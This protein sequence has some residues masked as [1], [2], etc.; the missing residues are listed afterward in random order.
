MAYEKLFTPGK[1]GNV[2]IKN[3]VVMPPMMLGFGQFDGKP[4]EKMMN[5]YEER[6]IGGAGLIVTE[7]T[8]VNDFS[9]ASAFAQLAISHDY[10]I[11][12]LKEMIDRVHR[13]GAKMFIQLHHPGRQNLGLMMG[14]V[15]VSIAM[16]KLIGN[17]YDKLFYKV[18]PMGKKLMEK[19]LVLKTSSP[20]QC[21]R[22]YSAESLNRAMSIKEIRK[23]IQQFIDGAVRA[24]KAGA[25]GVELHAAHGY[26]IQ[27]FLS[28]YTNQRT[29]CYG[30]SFE[31]RL[32][33]LAEI[34]TGIKS[35]CGKD[36]PII[37]RLS[38][39]ECYKEIGKSGVGYTLED[40]VKMAKEIEKMG[41]DAIDV[42][43]AG[44][45]TYNYWLEPTSFQP[46]WRKYM[47]AAVKKEVSIPV[48][49]ANLIRSPE[50]A[51]EQLEAGIQDF[52]CLG[53]PH[54]A[55]PHWANKAKEGK[56]N[57]I[58]RC[59]C[60]LYCMESMQHNAYAGTH[61]NCSVNPKLGHE[62]EVLSRDGNGRTVVIVG[63]GPAGLSAAET[64][65]KRGFHPIVLEKQPEAGG[66]LQLANK[67]PLKDKINWCI[68]D[69]VAAAV[70]NGAEIRYNT[71]ATPERIDSLSPYAVLIAT[72]ASSVK[73]R[74]IPGVD[75]P[76]VCTTTEVLNGVVRPTRQ[77]V[78]VIGSGMTGL[79]T[80]ELLCEL[81]NQV[82]VVEMADAIAPGT[83]MQHI[84]DCMP[85]LLAAGT[86]FLPAHKLCAIHAGD[87]EVLNV[88]T[89]AKQSIDT[90]FV[91]LSL[92]V[93]SDNALYALLK[94]KYSKI[95][96]IGDAEK[97]GRIAD[98]TAQGYKIARD[99]K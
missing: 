65:G 59:I 10:H 12:P 17:C 52:V 24:K 11:A 47:A 72:G 21:A 76:N 57:E 6:A 86:E 20:S 33:F 53:R 54:I 79:E 41:A 94:S 51:E 39:D 19:D 74:A 43:S 63:A 1:I 49:A 98:A 56:A 9:G 30:G 67:P 80:A 89:Q 82:T 29:D 99:L 97:T 37:V 68:E 81:Q 64:L 90:D 40:G 35:A 14:T 16:H 8:R 50:Q 87:I 28:P 45:D 7:I 15:P 84:D 91:V 27:Q 71:E 13:H 22:A 26:L 44:Y 75:L 31:N 25:D 46:G 85:R 62:K 42:S 83:W 95:Y 60:C 5:Y 70:H 2:E 36:F 3:R 34:L 18:A 61:A 69:L 23:I 93:R 66:Q 55:D 78:A 48:L 73:P 58:K 96:C 77:K 4:T 88:K 92:G 32:R 38:V